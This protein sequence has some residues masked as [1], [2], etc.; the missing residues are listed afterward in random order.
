MRL[1]CAIRHD[2][3]T[4]SG[5]CVHLL[6]KRLPKLRAAVQFPREG[7]VMVARRHVVVSLSALAGAA[8]SGCGQKTPTSIKIGVVVALSGPFAP[9]GNDLLRGAQLAAEELNRMP[10]KI[11]GRAVPIEIIS[12]DDKGEVD[13]AVAGARQ[14]LEAGAVAV[15]GPLNTP[16]AA[17]MIPVVAEAGKPHLFT[18]TA[19]NLH[20]AGKGNT[21]RL[22]ANDD[23]Q[24]KAAASFVQET[25]RAQRIAVVYES[26]DYGKGLNSAFTEALTQLKGK[27]VD[28]VAVDSK[29][30]ITSEL[31]RKLK[32]DAIDTVVFFSRDPHLKGLFKSLQEVGHTGVTVVGSNVVRNRTTIANGVPVK[33]MYATATAID[34]KEF[35]N[36]ARFV[37]AFEAQFKEP[38]VWGAHYAYDA[39]HA[40]AGAAASIESVEPAK[41]IERLKTKEPRTR[42]NEQMRW[43]PDGEQKY[44]SIAVYEA[45]RG[46]WQLQ[47]RSSQW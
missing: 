15:I 12:A 18:S 16:Q 34:A 47:M 1:E 22:L 21:F 10:F 8:L 3:V 2:T 46:A 38:P 11:A 7:V 5:A 42:V 39:V 32:A 17:K 35:V 41:L 4:R 14:V 44:A 28:A 40:I 37:E 25:L 24:G 30:E 19:A 20:A 36:G 45:E 9:R 43:T 29:S 13:A 23:L 6:E 33:A 31:A 27:V 26:G